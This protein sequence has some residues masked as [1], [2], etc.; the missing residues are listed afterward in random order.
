MMKTDIIVLHSPLH[1][2]ADYGFILNTLAEDGDALDVLVVN[3]EP[4][5]FDVLC[6]FGPS[7]Y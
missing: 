3:Y 7:E 4:A 2:P 6:R 1:Y 5:F